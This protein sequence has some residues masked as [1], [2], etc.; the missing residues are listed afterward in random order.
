MH[1]GKESLHIKVH[2]RQVDQIGSGTAVCR[3]CSA[4][5]QPTGMTP[6]DLDDCDRTV[7]IHAAVLG[8]FH[9]RCCY[10]FSG[11]GIAGAVVS[12]E[13]VIVDRLGHA[14]HAALPI[15]R[16]HIAA[17]L[18]AGI[19]GVIAAVIEEVAYIVFL[20]NLQNAPIIRIVR[21]R[22][23]HLVTAGA[24]FRRRCV[25]QQTELVRVLLTDV[26]QTVIQ[27]PADTVRRAVNIGDGIRFQC[28]LEHAVSAGVDDSSRP[29][30][31]PKDTRTLQYTGHSLP[32]QIHKI[33]RF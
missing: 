19:H 21:F 25:Q 29:S 8:D 17:D 27:N 10:V 1:I 20:K 16:L 9:A 6:H 32:P 24:Q 23:S 26:I 5:G 4:S 33:D 14:H 31:L 22:V 3:Q 7:I 2:L 28:G 15:V 11:A 12:A 18:I 13:E 30:G